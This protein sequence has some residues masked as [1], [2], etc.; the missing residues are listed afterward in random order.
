MIFGIAAA[1]VVVT[2]AVVVISGKRSSRAAMLAIMF[3]L[4]A[5]GCGPQSPE[6][7]MGS[8]T[9]TTDVETRG[10]TLSPTSSGSSSSGGS[11]GCVCRSDADC[12]PVNICDEGRCVFV[13]DKTCPLT[14]Q[15]GGMCEAPSDYTCAD[16]CDGTCLAC[17]EA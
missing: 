14:C 15:M 16:G 9:W 10:S 6:P 5:H 8:S 13:C 12:G 3:L 7:P 4:S 2:V 11:D 17:P 1:A